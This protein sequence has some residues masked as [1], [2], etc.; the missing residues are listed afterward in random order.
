MENEPP[1]V[2]GRPC[3]TNPLSLYRAFSINIVVTAPHIQ[4]GLAFGTILHDIDNR[5]KTYD[6]KE[7]VAKT[8]EG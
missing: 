8:G 1:N 2:V 5:N 4:D 6:L 7:G 3:P